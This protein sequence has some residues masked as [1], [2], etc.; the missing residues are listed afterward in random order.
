MFIKLILVGIILF[1]IIN[2]FIE[3]NNLPKVQENNNI[4]KLQQESTISPQKPIILQNN[5]LQTNK[6][7]R[8]ENYSDITPEIKQP[9]QQPRPQQQYQQQAQ[10]QQ[11][12]QAQQLPLPQQQEMFRDLEKTIQKSSKPKIQEIDRPYPWT[13]IIY[14]ENDDYPYYF[15]IKINIPSLN[16]Y[17]NWQKVIPNIDFNPNTKE[18]I[19]PSKDEAGALALANLMCINFS[20]QMTMQE[21]LKKD[22]IRIS[23]TKAKTHDVVRNKLR[24]QIMEVIYGKSFNTVQTKYEEDLAK[25][26]L[27]EKNNKNVSVKND[28]TSLKSDNFKDTFLHFSNDSDDN[29]DISAYDGGNYSYI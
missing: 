22:L 21:I 15:H 1:I 10:L 5:E 23:I 20:G 13:K 24:E 2:Q 18:I 29:N 17:E 8:L 19:I 27:V 26:G 9:H 14:I 11:Q 4:S 12:Y 6:S 25:N 16:D 7:T 3:N 28:I